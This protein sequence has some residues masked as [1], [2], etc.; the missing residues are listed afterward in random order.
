MRRNQI[1]LSQLENFLLK[2]ADILRG[3]MD[4]SEYKEHI[5]GM[6]FLKRMSD[7]FDVQRKQIRKQMAHLPSEEVEKLLEEEDSYKGFF[8]PKEARWNEAYTDA[9]GQFVSAIKDAKSNVGERLNTAVGALE[10]RNLSLMGVLKNNIN[11]NQT[12]GKTKIPDSKWIDLID[13]FNQPKFILINDNFEFPDLLG[14]AYEYLIK[15][16]ADS[17][18]KKAGEFYTPAEV[19]RLLVQ[20][21]KPEA[22]MSIYDPTVGSG[23]M[24]IQSHSYI[25]E[26]GQ[27]VRDLELCGQE[28]S[29]TVW[30]ICRM[31]LI[32]HNISGDHI[33]NDDTLVNPLHLENG[34]LRTFHRVLANP[35]FSQSYSRQN[36]QFENRFEH[37]FTPE[38]GKKGDLMFLQ[39]MIASLKEDGLMATIMPHGILFRGGQEKVIRQGII[40]KDH[41]EAVISLPAGLF[42]GTGIAACVLVI[43]KSKSAAMK[44]QILFINAD[45]EYAEGKAQNKL[46]PEDIQ[47]IEHV[48]T[49]KV[50]LPKYSKLVEKAKI[51]EHD[52]NLNIRR[53][54]DNTPD[55]EP[56]DVRAHLQG[57][58]PRAEVKAH[59]FTLAKFGVDPMVVFEARDDVYLDFRP[60][61]ATKAQIKTII[62]NQ[63]RLHQTFAA[64]NAA[65]GDWW[66]VARDDFSQLGIYAGQEENEQRKAREAM[67]HVRAELLATIKTKL[68]PM[69]VLDEFQTAGI[70]VNW[71]QNIKY[72]LKT[73]IASGWHHTLIPDSYLIA[74]FFEGDERAIELLEARQSEAEAQR[75]EALSA[76]EYEA[77]ESED[78]KEAELTATLLKSYLKIQIKDLKASGNAAA[79]KEAQVLA[80]QLQAIT[81]A[82]KSISAVKKDI[83]EARAAL[84]R[85]LRFKREGIEDGRL[86]LNGLLK[87]NVE[88]ANQA[89]SLPESTKKE[90]NAKAKK[91]KNLADDRTKLAAALVGLES[92]L[93]QI[94]GMLSAEDAKRLILQ[95]LHDQITGELERYLNA[96]K[97]AMLAVF[98]KLWDKYF[99]SSQQ[100][101]TQRR[102]TLH[103]LDGMLS[104]LGYVGAI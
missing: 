41:I 17:A 21:L 57:G 68:V 77:E 101:E 32:L 103:E 75:E 24:L 83:K 92:E 20:I 73:I 63:P 66:G 80:A 19:V 36:M 33:E 86:D 43:N 59:N 85:K 87:A 74:E 37:G 12:K 78:G 88:Q 11:F 70:F 89:Q 38:T 55:P 82:E 3:K 40:D 65:I 1:T 10:D 60:E 58:V 102:C 71:W 6:L 35:P 42:Y 96:E 45:A 9:E 52:Y 4:A 62:E 2:A 79:Q 44:K 53:Y 54:V 94:G 49:H 50:E 23:G 34:V 27:N 100:L 84:E 81:E 7:E 18:G 90:Q 16:F 95:K 46:R 28:S 97:R 30:A 26:Q 99:V 91:L 8:V 13:H 51:V 14:A 67:A 69:G 76:V 104:R 25:E 64:M 29:G 47:K 56:Q 39:H 5:F 22:G 93:Q 61:A 15:Y 72:D 48:Y 31:N 98:E